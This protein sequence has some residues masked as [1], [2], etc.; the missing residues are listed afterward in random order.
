MSNLQQETDPAVDVVF[1]TSSG[2]S[3]E[4]QQE[5]LAGINA[6]AGGSRL[7]SGDTVIEAKKKGFLFPMVVNITAVVFLGLGFMFLF[8]FHG[9]EDQDIR[10]YSASLGITERKLIQEIRQETNQQINEKEKEIKNIRSMLSTVDSEYR[11]LQESVETLTEEQ[12]EKAASLLAMQEE[13]RNTLS[14]LEEEK[15]MI[16]EDSRSKEANLRA[17]A[18][19]R[20][21][22][23]AS[24]V[25]QGQASLGAAM[26]EL[27]LLGSEQERAARAESQM[28]GFYRTLNNQIGSGSLDEASGTLAAMKEFLAAPAFQGIR[29]LEARKQTHMAAIAAVEGMITEAR[30]LK[31][32]AARS[33]EMVQPQQVSGTQDE[34]PALAAAEERYASLDARYAVLEKKASDQEKALAALSAQGSDQ[35]VLIA[36]YVSENNALRT[37]NVNQQETL[38]RRDNEIVSLRAENVSREQQITALNTNVTAMRAQLQTANNNTQESEAA[39]AAQRRENAALVAARE[40]LQRQYD[41]LQRRMDAAVRAFTGE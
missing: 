13:Y 33:S 7:V 39:L 14:V 15:T 6:I 32:A 40:E 26:E 3:L 34:A 20:A 35:G 17:H 1:D 25:E 12:K 8:L 9:Q 19:E 41:D 36:G 16:I 23:L 22:E 29:T 28:N 27:R 24:Q 10:E 30:L 38:N 18:E 21:N 4:E 37:A 5:I 11:V 31:E 2:I